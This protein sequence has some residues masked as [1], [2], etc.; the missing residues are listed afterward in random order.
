[1][2]RRSRAGTRIARVAVKRLAA[3]GAG[4]GHDGSK[5]VFVPYSA[6]GDEVEAEIFDERRTWCRARIRRVL[7]PSP[8]RVS[9]R[10]E[11]FG[12][13]GGCD[14][15]HLAYEAQLAAKKTIV[16]E[17]LRRIGRLD[18]PEVA[19]VVPS[20][21]TY[22][23]RCR[24]R[25]HAAVSGGAVR[26]GFFRAGSH[27]VV[28]VESCPVLHPSL[29][30]ALAALAA[31][32]RRQPADFDRVA[33]ARLDTCW[34]GSLVRLSLR[35]ARGDSIPL[36]ATALR[37]L[38]AAAA[39][40]GTRLLLGE[41]A[42]RPL[43][44]GPGDDA[45]VTTGETFTQVNLANNQA[46]VATALGLAAPRPGEAALDL[47][48]G[49][50]NLA[51]PAAARGARVLGVD[52]DAEAVRQARENAARLGRQAEFVRGDAA[53]TA[54]ELVGEGRRFP[55][56]LLNPPRTGAREAVPAVAGLAPGRIVMISC[57]PAT[58]A[59]DASAFSA[60]GYRLEA[61]APIDLFP[62]TA[63]VETVA[64]FTPGP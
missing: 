9:P 51:L 11:A 21:D 42:R 2:S 63:H 61:L 55:L 28:P 8:E 52:L 60:A 17:A 34:D 22:E 25:L 29:E 4:V 24:A 53:S 36:A 43:A 57:N 37:E 58:L 56:V 50:G 48:C 32:A 31:A 12:A 64:L 45:L 10:C 7:R 14:W 30:A 5:V 62:Q 20:P 3:G 19:P 27:E 47:Y 15:Q 35:G 41:E 40:R 33:Q 16:A 49:L 44:M 54:R 23:Y 1:M 26:F 59:R 13:C 39:D 46:L 6:P 18:P 38:L